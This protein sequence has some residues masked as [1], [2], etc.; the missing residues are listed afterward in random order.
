[1][2]S[3][4]HRHTILHSWRSILEAEA[5]RKV[6]HNGLRWGLAAL[7]IEKLGGGRRH[8]PKML[9]TTS[10]GLTTTLAPSRFRNRNRQSRTCMV[11][12]SSIEIPPPIRT[13]HTG[14]IWAA[15]TPTSCA[16]GPSPLASSETANADAELSRC[17]TVQHR[18]CILVSWL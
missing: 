12:I 6:Q 8:N 2:V 18:T 14:V 7:P 3:S 11:R 4:A 10:H 13:I 17:W 9:M 15:G 1:M 5:L 16:L